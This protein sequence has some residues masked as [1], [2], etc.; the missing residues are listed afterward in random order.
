MDHFTCYAHAE[1]ENADL[2]ELHQRCA[3]GEMLDDSHTPVCDRC[4]GAADALPYEDED[5]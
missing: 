5:R 3:C 2:F 1:E 4:D